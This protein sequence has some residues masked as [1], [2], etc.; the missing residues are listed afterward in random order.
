MFNIAF[1]GCGR[2]SKNHFQA[3]LDNRDITELKYLCDIDIEKAR[4]KKDEFFNKEEIIITDNYEEILKDNSI[5]VVVIT[6]D[7]GSHYEIGKKVLLA[8]KH[9]LIEKPMAIRSEDA[10]DMT[11]IANKK[12]LQLGVCHQNRFNKT[13]YTV[14][15]NIENDTI[16]NIASLS[17]RVLWNRDE[18][19]YGLADWRGKKKTDGSILHNQCIHGID[20]LLWY[21]NS[22]VKEVYSIG[23]RFFRNFEFDDH[24]HSIVEFENGIIAHIE[25]SVIV[26]GGN[27]EET[28]DICAENAYIRLGGKALNEFYVSR[29]NNTDE[30]FSDIKEE[31][32]DVYGNGH[33]S[34]YRNYFNALAGKEKLVVSSKEAFKAIELI[35]KIAER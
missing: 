5:D 26:H 30:Y 11:N 20:M 16:K 27:L 14:K 12:N 17:V 34:L 13:C 19:Y 7:S 9:L 22:N 8:N 35:N 23:N 33:T 21:A 1:I 25:G 15:E 10:L 2:I 31:I 28:L 3:I 6:T 18:N 4:L 32:K 24:I 29:L